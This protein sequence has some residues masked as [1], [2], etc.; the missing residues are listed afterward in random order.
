MFRQSPPF[1]NARTRPPSPIFLGILLNLFMK[2]AYGS[3]EPNHSHF[4]ASAHLKNPKL[5]LEP[6]EEYSAV[7]LTASQKK[8]LGHSVGMGSLLANIFRLVGNVR[9]G[10][11]EQSHIGQPPRR[12]ATR[13]ELGRTATPTAWVAPLCGGAQGNRE[14]LP[15]KPPSAPSFTDMLNFASQK[16]SELLTPLE[17]THKIFVLCERLF[18]QVMS[19]SPGASACGRPGSANARPLT[20][21]FGHIKMRLVWGCGRV[22]GVFD[23]SAHPPFLGSQSVLSHP[24][25]ASA[26]GRPGSANAR[27]LTSR[28][29]HIKMRLVWGCGRVPG[30]FD[31]SAHPPFLRSQPG[32]AVAKGPLKTPTPGQLQRYDS[33]NTPDRTAFFSLSAFAMSSLEGLSGSN[34]WCLDDRAKAAKPKFFVQPS[35]RWADWR[36]C[37][38]VSLL[39]GE[40]KFRLRSHRASCQLV[41]DYTRPLRGH[42][43]HIERPWPRVPSTPDR[44]T[45]EQGRAAYK[46]AQV[47]VSAIS[48][49]YISFFEFP[50][51]SSRFLWT[52]KLRI[53]SDAASDHNALW[54]MH[55]GR[56]PASLGHPISRAHNMHRST[57][58]RRGGRAPPPPTMHVHQPHF[59]QVISVSANSRN[60]IGHAH[61]VNTQPRDVVPSYVQEDLNTNAAVESWDFSYDLGDTTLLGEVQV[62][63]TDGIVLT[64]KKKVYENSDYPMLTWANEH[65]DEY[66]NE[67]L[68]LEGRGYP[69]IYST[70]GGCGHADPTFSTYFVRRSLKDLGLVIQ[71]GHPAGTSCPNSTKAH[72]DFVLIDVTGVHE[73]A[74]NYCLCDS[75]IKERQQLMRV[76]WWPA[77]ARAPQTCATFAVVRLFRTLNCLGKVSAHDFLKSLE[78]LT[79]NDGLV[80]VPLRLTVHVSLGPLSSL[81]S[82]R[83]PVQDHAYDEARGSRTRSFGR[84]RDCAG[85]AGT[86]VSRLSSSRNQSAGRMG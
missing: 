25:G 38:H 32:Y 85:R 1:Y 78:L 22:P 39:T 77:T 45:V 21:R 31:A 5:H 33:S 17:L 37:A 73:I 42:G 9:G 30:V 59:G 49:L 34:P 86:A 65:Q 51:P 11:C 43:E 18:S 46:T 28:F 57:K 14:S 80:P 67:M 54:S 64:K 76:C 75:N 72:K 69:A 24:P 70:C 58:G 19:H 3:I 23:A 10:R 62:P 27:L 61:I 68:R 48:A 50:L 26:C 53:K 74:L 29:G 66:L 60:A 35:S 20:S 82:H 6:R 47:R 7:D 16:R 56:R 63:E 13:R 81:P 84:P 83:P 36:R 71:L 4:G 52:W 79:N 8:Y 44:E 2:G 55:C 15:R 12:T 40:S 41:Y